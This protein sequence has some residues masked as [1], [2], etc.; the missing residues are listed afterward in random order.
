MAS[1]LATAATSPQTCAFGKIACVIKERSHA[2]LPSPLSASRSVSIVHGPLSGPAPSVV[3]CMRPKNAP[4]LTL[5]FRIG[6]NHQ[7]SGMWLDAESNRRREI[8]RPGPARRV[9]CTERGVPLDLLARRPRVPEEV[10]GRVDADHDRAVDPLRIPPGVDQRRPCPRAF[11]EEV[12]ALVAQ[13]LA[14]G[15]EVVDAL[16][17]G[18]PGEVERPRPGGA[19]R[20]S[21]YAAASA[22]I[23]FSVRI[24]ARLLAGRGHLG[25]VEPRRA[26]DAAVADQDDVVLLGVSARGRER[27]VRDARTA[28]EPEDRLRRIGRPCPDACHRQRDQARARLVPVLRDDERATVGGVAAVLRRVVAVVEDQVARLRAGRDRDRVVARA[29]VDVAEARARRA[30][31]RRGRRC[32]RA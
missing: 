22:R 20:T 31:S 26:V 8:R 23:A 27:H 17:E 13:R 4:S 28:L 24:A 9:V 25:T 3:A 2:P 14:G 11:A 10:A 29:D 18:V 32:G 12:D 6:R 21:W 1:A 5:P 7:W 16:R 15:F 30:R 19:P